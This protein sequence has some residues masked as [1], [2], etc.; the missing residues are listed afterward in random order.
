M[1]RK[2]RKTITQTK[3]TEFSKIVVIMIV[4]LWV[5]VVLYS[6]VIVWREPTL[7]SVLK[8]MVV[9]PAVT[10]V[11]AYFAKSAFANGKKIDWE[12][13]QRQGDPSQPEP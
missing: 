12:I 4:P 5:A 1:A 2:K 9:D 8:E 10:V 3:M 11:I 13:L 7:L 6:A